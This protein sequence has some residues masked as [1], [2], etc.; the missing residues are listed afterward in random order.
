M[1]NHTRKK[2][3]PPTKKN[4]ETDAR[5]RRIMAEFDQSM[6]QPAPEAKALA[7]A[8]HINRK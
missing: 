3:L 7:D 8:F 4:E 2:S 1:W 5:I 6:G